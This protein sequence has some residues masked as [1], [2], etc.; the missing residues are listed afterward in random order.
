[1]VTYLFRSFIDSNVLDGVGELVPPMLRCLLAINRTIVAAIVLVRNHDGWHKFG[2]FQVLRRYCNSLRT[3]IVER[4][5]PDHALD[6]R[7]VTLHPALRLNRTVPL[8]YRMYTMV[9]LMG[10]IGIVAQLDRLLCA[11]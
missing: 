7:H 1:M 2:W 6:P 4:R 3:A 9:R 10:L 8:R 5:S 11:A